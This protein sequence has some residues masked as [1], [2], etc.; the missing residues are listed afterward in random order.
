[1][2]GTCSDSDPTRPSLPNPADERRR[3][4]AARAGRGSGTLCLRAAADQAVSSLVSKDSI[5]ATWN[6]RSIRCHCRCHCWGRRSLEAS[7]KADGLGSRAVSV[8]RRDFCT[9]GL[10]ETL[11]LLMS[12]E[13]LLRRDGPSWRCQPSAP[14]A[15]IAAL[16]QRR[17]ERARS[18]ARRPLTSRPGPAVARAGCPGRCDVTEAGSYDASVP[19]VA[20]LDTWL[21]P[22]CKEGTARGGDKGCRV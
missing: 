15:Q 11:M 17:F 3:A 6:T 22:T 7:P 9:M 21:T 13:F 19:K 5:R 10:T 14:K 18:T 4:V 2:H 8:T 12:R 20:L 16:R 1:M